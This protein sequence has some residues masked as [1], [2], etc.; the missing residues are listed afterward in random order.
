MPVEDEKMNPK[1]TT[2]SSPTN[3][4]RKAYPFSRNCSSPNTREA[5][6]TEYPIPVDVAVAYIEAFGS[7]DMTTA[8]RYVAE[9][10]VFE[11]PRT[12]IAGAE[13]YLEA[14][15]RFAQAVTGVDIIAVFGDDERAM[16]M[17]DMKTG[18]FGTLR[19]ADYFV[20]RD[21]KIESDMLVFD[22]HEVRKAEA[23]RAPSA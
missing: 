18:P 3:D 1:K 15:G 19:A 20:I 5:I 9:D 10:I 12:R 17:Y 4:L 6:M 16:I 11:S 22:T 23:A 21:S 14:V 13:P 8:A 2:V 7:R